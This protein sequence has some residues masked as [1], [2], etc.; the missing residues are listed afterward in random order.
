ML[1]CVPTT[2]TAN[3]VVDHRRHYRTMRIRACCG[4]YI[5]LC[6]GGTSACGPRAFHRTSSSRSSPYP[7][8]HP[9]T[10]P[11]RSSSPAA[12]T[13][14]PHPQAAA[15]GRLSR[16]AYQ[17]HPTT[18]P[19]I[20]K[21]RSQTRRLQAEAANSHRRTLI[22]PCRRRPV[23]GRGHRRLRASS[24]RSSTSSRIIRAS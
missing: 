23:R 19:R 12:P 10:P 16:R 20:Q 21:R 18:R 1:L 9:T 7:Q 2:R 15:T 24:M 3:V 17:A 13:P 5:G 22:R 14:R 11:A 8:A 6:A 4:K